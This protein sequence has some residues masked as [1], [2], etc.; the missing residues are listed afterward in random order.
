MGRL[1]S[2]VWSACLVALLRC[3][4]AFSMAQQVAII[5]PLSSEE[6]E[7]PLPFFFDFVEGPGSYD[8]ITIFNPSH[9]FH[10]FFLDVVSVVFPLE[11][12]PSPPPPMPP[13]LEL[14]P[15]PLDNNLRYGKGKSR[16]VYMH[17]LHKHTTAK[18][19][20]IGLCITLFHS[21]TLP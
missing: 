13:P 4:I 10:S 9:Q 19:S 12:P 14:P 17:I 18:A 11:S 6:F 21:R 20:W 2:L 5:L 8:V 7:K 3:T 1:G 15:P 16:C